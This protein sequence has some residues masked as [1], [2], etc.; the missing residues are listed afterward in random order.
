MRGLTGL[1]G[2]EGL[3]DQRSW[4]PAQLSGLVLWLRADAGTFQDS[5]FTT[6]ATDGSAL[7]GW[8]DQSGL[9]HHA[10]QAASAQKMTWVADAGDGRAAVRGNGTSSNLVIASHADFDFTDFSLCVVGAFRST[11]AVFQ[12]LVARDEGSGA[13]KKWI[14]GY[15]VSAVNAMQLHVNDAAGGQ[16]FINSTTFT[17]TA[18][19][20]HNW[21]L[22]KNGT[23]ISHY[24]DG[25]AYGS[26]TTS[27]WTTPAADVQI[28]AASTDGGYA[29]FDF[30]EIVLVNRAL[31]AGEQA[32]LE[33]WLRRWGTP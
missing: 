9:G 24:R 11:S 23:G 17:P 5:G 16:P 12:T 15:H 2:L 14:Y 4:T 3:V 21:E 1:S 8:R 18:G 10:G 19:E 7:G 30:R 22:F 32:N 20:F 25:S 26:G 27:V 33:S 13:N 6:A 28:G 31:A 29:N